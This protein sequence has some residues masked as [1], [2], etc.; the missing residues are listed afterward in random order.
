MAWKEYLN[1]MS[2]TQR[3]YTCT[4]LEVNENKKDSIKDGNKNKVI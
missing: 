4:N 2:K 1:N 3:K